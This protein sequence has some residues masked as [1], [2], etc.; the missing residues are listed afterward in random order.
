M[1][2]I[3]PAIKHYTWGIPCSNSII[4]TF[5]DGLV[6]NRCAEAW[7][8]SHPSG[9]AH[10]TDLSPLQDIPYLL[11]LISVGRPLSLQLHPD[12]ESALMLHNNYPTL[13]PDTND[14]PEMVVAITK[15]QALCGFL[16]EEQIRNNLLCLEQ[17]HITKFEDIFNTAIR[18]KTLSAARRIAKS[19]KTVAKLIDI[20]PNDVCV[21][22]PLFMNIITLNPGEALVIPPNEAHCYLSGQGVECMKVS[23]NVVRIGLTDKLCCIPEFLSLV[24]HT[25]HEPIVLPKSRKYFHKVFTD[26]LELYR[27]TSYHNITTPGILVV[28]QGHLTTNISVNTNNHTIYKGES[29]YV[30]PHDGESIIL[31]G[32]GFEA[33]FICKN[34]EHKV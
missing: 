6:I 5:A 27:V 29:F 1:R 25:Y 4:P 12:K 10:F 3:F 28:T 14:K 8:G 20:Y 32:K 23:D 13:F 16:P 24:N 2:R 21:L 19:N 17:E 9:P 34:F 22:A 15:F 30:D 33:F 31:I 7:W 26:V 11:K 18:D